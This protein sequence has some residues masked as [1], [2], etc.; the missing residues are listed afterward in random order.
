MI[1]TYNKKYLY[2]TYDLLVQL[3]I[4]IHIFRLCPCPLTSDEEDD[5]RTPRYP[6]EIREPEDIPRRPKKLTEISESGDFKEVTEVTEIVEPEETFTES[7]ETERITKI[8]DSVEPK[9]SS[10]I[11]QPKEAPKK[12]IPIEETDSP[13]FERM[14]QPTPKKISE[15]DKVPENDESLLTVTEKV[16]NKTFNI[17]IE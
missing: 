14:V 5:Y 10:A 3:D 13:M 6:D 17:H 4:F 9:R 11:R 1:T 15:V 2:S 8:K 12:G 7:Y 16:A